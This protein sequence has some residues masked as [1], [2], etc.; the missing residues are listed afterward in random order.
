METSK[1]LSAVVN[2]LHQHIEYSP[3]YTANIIAKKFPD[4]PANYEDILDL[5]T[6][7]EFESLEKAAAAIIKLVF[8]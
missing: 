5:M 2:I 7:E 1:N 6:T 3:E 4:S 8:A